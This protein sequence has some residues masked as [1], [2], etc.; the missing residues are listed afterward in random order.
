MCN[1]SFTVKFVFHQIICDAGDCIERIAILN[2]DGSNGLACFKIR[3]IIKI[4][5]IIFFIV[6]LCLTQRFYET[7]CE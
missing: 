3:T 1:G 7:F 4:A 2:T 5:I 6:S